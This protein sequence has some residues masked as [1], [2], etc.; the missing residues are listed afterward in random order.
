MF[1]IFSQ[2]PCCRDSVFPCKTSFSWVQVM[3]GAGLPDVLQVN[4]RLVPSLIDCMP[5]I[6]VTLARTEKSN[7]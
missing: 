2:A 5:V 7:H 1:F 6:L 3:F 4:S